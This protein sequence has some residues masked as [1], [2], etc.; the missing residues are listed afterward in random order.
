[1]R[2]VIVVACAVVAC[3]GT[4]ADIE[5]R[6][7]DVAIDTVELFIGGGLCLAPMSDHACASGVAWAT[8]MTEQPAGTILLLADT[9]EFTTKMSGGVA[10]F[11]LE[12]TPGHT[13]VAGAL[14]VG[15]ANGVPV[16]SGRLDGQPSIPTDH[17]EIWQLS[18]T[19]TDPVDDADP[20]AAPAS[21]DLPK[22]VKV[23]SSPKR[24]P[25][26]T[27]CAMTQH[28]NG[29]SWD[30][31]YFVP[32]N[33]R[34]C[35]GETIECDPYW[36]DF[37]AG[38]TATICL[39]TQGPADQ[40]TCTLGSALCADGTSAS[41]SCMQSSQPEECFAGDIC[42]SCTTSPSVDGDCVKQLIA[43]AYAA[44]DTMS[45]T[46]PTVPIADCVFTPDI[47][48]MG[49]CT[50]TATQQ[51]ELPADNLTCMNATLRPLMLPLQPVLPNP[52]MLGPANI[53]VTASSS[54][55]GCQISFD[56]LEGVVA[57]PPTPMPYLLDVEYSN[58]KHVVLPVRLSF[59]PAATCATGGPN[60]CQLYGS[61]DDMQF[62]CAM[63]Q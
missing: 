16:A 13:T 11:R 1:M 41:M 37:N 47:T 34:D 54:T 53:T 4:G 10:R 42:N 40:G 32:S 26:L 43:T 50:A 39:D 17:A 6:S 23:W 24:M 61:T 30:R 14:A 27:S 57:I 36:Y 51:L 18:L 44:V 48:S 60:Q 45:G 29:Q 20:D 5:V 25:G 15:L 9:Q 62:A 59:A 28:W 49:P 12:A 56:W 8:A 38:G 55:G 33:D 2:G 22:R 7:P 31:T 3:G 63:M 35:D 19:A 21:T 52:T 46:P 58:A